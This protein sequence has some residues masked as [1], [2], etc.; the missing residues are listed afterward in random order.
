MNAYA[1]FAVNNHLQ[2]LLDEA[3]ANRAANVGKPSFL[4]RIASAASSVKTTIH[5]P[6]DYS[7]SIIPTLQDHPYQS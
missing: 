3:A 4:E 7:N 6:A 1:V 2:E 5:A